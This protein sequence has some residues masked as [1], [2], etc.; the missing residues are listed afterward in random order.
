MLLPTLIRPRSRRMMGAAI[1]P[2]LAAGALVAS[3]L[4]PSF[5]AS[6]PDSPSSATAA[7]AAPTQTVTLDP[8]G[9]GRT[10][11]GIGAISGG[12]GTSR[13]LTDYPA[14]ER[15]QVLDYLFKPQYGA[16]LDILKVEIGGDTHSSNGA[17]PS[18]M[19]T[20]DEVDCNRGY[21]WWLME[22][23]RKRNP[24][25]TFYGLAWGAPGWLK[26]YWSEDTMHYFITWLGCAEQHHLHISYLGGR[27]EREPDA[28]WF[29]QFR[30]EL[31]D[32][33]Y[34]DVQLVAGDEAGYGVMDQLKADPDFMKAVDVVGIHYPCSA[35]RCTPNADAIESG[36]KLWASESGWNNYRTGA[37]RLGS[38][39]NHEYVDSKMT[40][41]INWPAVYSW[42]P[43][44]QYQDSGL[45]KANEP[46]SG[47]YDVG[48][49]LWTVAQTTQFTQPGWSYLDSA[50]TYLDGGGTTVA[51]KAPGAS[52]DW[53]VIAETTSATAPQTVRFQVGA[54]L[55]GAT[56]HA[57]STVLENGTD[58]QWFAPE[59]DPVVKDGSFEATLQPGR[60][61]TFST[62]AK[63]AKG[64]ASSPASAPM[65][66]GSD[67][68]QGYPLG[69]T[70]TY[71]SD[72]EGAFETAKCSGSGGKC[73][74]QVITQT[75]KTWMRTPYP[76][77]LYGDRTWQ[78]YTVATT[79]RLEQQ[80]STAIAARVTNEYNSTKAPRT[81]TWT[82]YWFWVDDTGAWRLEAHLPQ[83][84]I[85]NGAT[86]VLASGTLPDGFGV[87]QSHR[88][89]L[90]VD[91]DQLTPLVD[92]KPV[93]TITDGTFPEG[94]T[95]LAVDRYA[96]VQYDDYAV[97]PH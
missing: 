64:T 21:E 62:V 12:G 42:Y 50:S 24:D 97:V 84:R 60:V 70:P 65:P 68:F 45:M 28:A 31:D 13:L 73:L 20:P 1:V 5:A 43:T 27:N 34:S 75:P 74:R 71:F 56:V 18:H 11:D 44:V 59:P 2:V 67:D 96:P 26:G 17:E 36:K 55:S 15:N 29:V 48:A 53:S 85:N 72:M 19:R 79:V 40:A 38:E 25:I 3:A 35:L 54:G 33:G 41:F 47:S 82:G 81:N 91:G 7:P 95:G 51:L 52:A 23:A 86:K 39:I 66:Y 93:T 10:F 22:Q 32:A 89:A 4:T 6:S 92:G 37:L 61:Y 78:D 63:A 30:K 9:G 77:T 14:K 8:S 57:V 87:D 49:S 94:Q 69:S 46:W 80:S 90:C 83:D 16:S 88:V 76:I 58:A